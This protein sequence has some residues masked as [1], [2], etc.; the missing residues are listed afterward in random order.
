MNTTITPVQ[1]ADELAERIVG[2]VMSGGWLGASWPTY[3]ALAHTLDTHDCQCA[4]NTAKF[5][6]WSEDWDLDV[7]SQANFRAHSAEL[8]AQFAACQGD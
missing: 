3:P 2:F 4:L 6:A 1:T 7:A 5:L 8:D